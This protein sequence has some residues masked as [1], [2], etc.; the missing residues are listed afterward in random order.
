MTKVSEPFVRYACSLVELDYLILSGKTDSEQAL[1]LRSELACIYDS[2]N[3]LE[4]FSADTLAFK[5][6][7]LRISF[8]ENNSSIL[9]RFIKW[10]RKK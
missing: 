4:K 1:M 9:E 10:I 3:D 7:D 5:L 6:N 2:F 8:Q